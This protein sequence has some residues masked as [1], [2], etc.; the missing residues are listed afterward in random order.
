MTYFTLYLDSSESIFEYSFPYI[1]LDKEFE[2]ALLK[3]DGD[4]ELSNKIIINQTNNK[5]YYSVNG[6]DKDNKLISK[7][8]VINIPNGK[9]DLNELDMKINDELIERDQNFFQIKRKDNK[10]CFEIKPAYSIDFTKQNTFTFG[11]NSKVLKSGKHISDNNF[12]STL[13]NIFICCN[14]IEDAY[15]NSKKFN[16]L[17]RFKPIDEINIEPSIIQYHKVITRPNKIQLTLVDI[18][19]NLIDFDNINLLVDLKLKEVR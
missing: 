6:T 9:Y 4:L 18:N 3:I 1:F 5:F 14:L 8:F 17:Y 13:D 11:Y 12:R 19:N 7:D 10:I 2:I 15:V 16:T